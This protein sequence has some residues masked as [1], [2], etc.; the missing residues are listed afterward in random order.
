MDLKTWPAAAY[1]MLAVIVG[2]TLLLAIL[3]LTISAQLTAAA[4]QAEHD[5]VSAIC[6]REHERVADLRSWLACVE[7]LKR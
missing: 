2:S 1:V 4:E 7:E 5:R 6:D 3:G